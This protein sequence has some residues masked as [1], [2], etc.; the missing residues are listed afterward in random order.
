MPRATRPTAPSATRRALRVPVGARRLHRLCAGLALLAACGGG[1]GDAARALPPEPSAPS[2]PA[3]SVPTPTVA[4]SSFDRIQHEILDRQCVGCHTSGMPYA[5]ESG[6][7]LESSQAFAQL[8]GVAATQAAARSDGLRRVMPFK[9]DSSLLYH[10]LA[11]ASGHHAH[12]YGLLMPMGTTEGI[13]LGQLEYVRRWIEA[14]AP[15]TGSV[16]DTMLLADRVGQRIAAYAPLAPPDR[17]VQ[18]RVDSFSVAPNFER[19]LFVYRKLGN[20]A[21]LF[22]DRIE[23][24]MRAG[25]HHFLL[26]AFDPDN[27]RFPCTV[28]PPADAV[29][30]I[31]NPDGSMNLIAMLPMACHVF[32]AGSMTQAGDYRFP[33]G[34]ALRLPANSALDLNVHYVNRTGAA[35]PGEA[36]VNLHAVD[37]SAVAHVASTLNMSNTDFELPPR[38]RTTVR[39]TFTVKEAMTVFTLT[40]HMHQL[41]ERFVVRVR[42]GARDG[43]IV[44]DN[45]DWEHPSIVTLAQPLV[46]RAGDGL[47]SEITWNNTTARTIR[48]GLTSED[49]MGIIF[50]YYY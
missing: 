47:T 18:L 41:G 42:G 46:L 4:L 36:A 10:K 12:D 32:V 31:R 50:G 14:G 39:K 1:S 15:R 49:E 27:Q 28:R 17:G 19:E 25:S 2:A 3:P 21:D 34:V 44:Y 45:T 8:V 22:V 33:A 9:A 11:W 20:A 6:L 16:V 37:R 29:R 40:S 13:S 5:R 23:T 38:A 7:A 30:D 24:R 26:Y 35:F 43:E 48:F